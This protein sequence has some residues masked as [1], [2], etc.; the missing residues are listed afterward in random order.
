MK[1]FIIGIII[2]ILVIILGVFCVYEFSFKPQVQVTPLNS[3][4]TLTEWS[5]AKKFIPKDINLS[6]SELSATSDTNFSNSDLTSLFIAVAKENPDLSQFIS[7]LQVNMEANNTIDVYANLLYNGIPVQ[8]HL[9]FTCTTTNGKGILHYQSGKVGFISI[10]KDTLFNYMQNN[11]IFQ[12]DK[13][14]GN[15]ILSFP[16]IKYLI[17]QSMSSTPDN[18]NI[19]FNAT[20]K[21]FNWLET[22]N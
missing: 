7:G 9:I 11:N 17:V 1:K 3:P 2:A 15:I 12:F 10:S 21:F 20:I 19:R 14:A 8:A 18:L 13:Q 4:S 16:S 5:L 22:N 6:L